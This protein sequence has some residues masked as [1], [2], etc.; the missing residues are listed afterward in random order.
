MEVPEATPVTIPE[1]PIVAIAVA[2]LL[3]VP[4]GVALV[5]VMVW[6]WQTPTG[7][8]MAASAFTVT[9]YV[10]LQPELKE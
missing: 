5:N 4:P 8:K 1:E 7:P 10:A 6:P 9:T 3:Q 2:L